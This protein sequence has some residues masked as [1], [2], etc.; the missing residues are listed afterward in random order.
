MDYRRL[1][2]GQK[3][4]GFLIA[5]ASTF[6]N[7]ETEAL[8]SALRYFAIWA[9]IYAILQTILLYTVDRGALETL[10]DLLGLN[11]AAVYLLNP[12]VFGLVG[13]LGAFASL[14][15]YGSWAH[16]F[17]RAFGGRKGYWNTIK[18]FAYGNTPLFLFGWIPFVGTLFSIW[19]LVLD[20]IG[21]RQLHEIST[22]RAIGAVLLSALALAIIVVLIVVAVVLSAVIPA[23]A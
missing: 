3:V 11:A 4:R 2:F 17:V 14:F 20:I 18:A 8:G 15:I 9:A 10:S 13:L 12:A 5:P 1:S 16:L 22:G 7:V 19:A 21:I 23:T 6:D